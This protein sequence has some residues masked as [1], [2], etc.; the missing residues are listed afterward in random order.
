MTRKFWV[1]IGLVLIFC[2]PARQA[3]ADAPGASALA[4][5]P[6]IVQR[7]VDPGGKDTFQLQIINVTGQALPVHLSAEPLN[8]SE[9][10]DDPVQKWLSFAESDIILKPGK[11]YT[12]KITVNPPTNAEPGGHYASIYIT[13]LVPVGAIS[14]M[15]TR[16]IVRVSVT[17]FIII[18]GDTREDEKL[19]SFKIDHSFQESAPVNFSL[20]LKNTGNVHLLSHGK[21]HIYDGIGKQIAEINMPDTVVLPGTGK[22]VHISWDKPWLAGH[23][24]AKVEITYGVKHTVLKSDKVSFWVIPWLPLILITIAGGLGLYIIRRTYRRWGRAL[25][26]LAGK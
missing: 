23:Y 3:G 19:E 10:K 9:Y 26:A 20:R 11:I 15:Q 17:A 18:K 1:L 4:V 16:Q 6:S 12:E 14:S 25:K 2:L 8:S 5:T 13:P 21:V 22:T 7:I 24:S